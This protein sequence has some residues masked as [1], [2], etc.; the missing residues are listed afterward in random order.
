[1]FVSGVGEGLPFPDACFDLVVM[2]QVVEHVADQSMVLREAARAVR[3][4]GVIYVA[5]PN[6]LRFYEPHYKIRMGASASEGL[7]TN[8]PS[9]AGAQ[10]GH[11]E[12]TDLHDQPAVAKAVGRSWPG[13]YRSGSAPRGVLEKAICWR[14]RGWINPPGGEADQ[15]ACGWSCGSMVRSHLWIDR[16]GRLCNGGSA[17]TEG[18]IAVTFAGKLWQRG[19]DLFPVAGFH[20]DRPLVLLQSDD[21]GRIG[22]RDRSGLEQLRSA[23]LA[24]GER[25]YDFYTLETAEDVRKLS[26]T[27]KGHR[28]SCGRSPCME[29]NFIVANL[30]FARMSGD[31]FRKVYLLP[32]CR[33]VSDGLD[34][35][36]S[37]GSVSRR[38]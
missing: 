32:A 10:S 7:G 8:I 24:L 38:N 20:F 19:R 30:D 28:D 31:G 37:G 36:R 18:G 11:A 17:Q 23:G 27:L 1:M 15:V 25:P 14:L 5:C 16:R 35:P 33:G 4:G 2:N 12:P 13:V 22:L 3:E 26:T 21:W 6:Y 34:P 29:M 9:L